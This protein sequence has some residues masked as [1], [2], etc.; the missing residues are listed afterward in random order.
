M[1]VNLTSDGS[2]TSGLG[3][4]GL[5]GQTVTISGK[6]YRLAAANSISTPISLG[7]IHVGS[8]FGTSA[9]SIQNTAT[10]DGYSEGLDAGFGS[11]TGAASD[12]SGTISTLAAGGAN[13][14]SMTVGLGSGSQGT[15]G[16]ISGTVLVNLTSDG[17]GTSGLGTSGLSGQTVTISGK[18]YRLAAANSIS[19]PI[20]LGNIHVGSA[21]GTSALSIQNTAT[22]DGYS[23]GLDAGF[24]SVTGSASDNSGT[25]SVLAAGGANGTSMTVGLGSGTQGTAG[26]ISG[27]VLVNL[28]SD[29]SGTSG[30]G[31]SGLGGQTVTISG[32]VYRL[33]AANT[34]TTPISLGNVHVG[35]AFGTSALS[36]SNTATNDGYSEGLDAGFGSVTGA[37]SDNSGTISTLAAG[38]ANSTSMT[39]GLGSGSQGTAG[40]ISGTVL[41]NLTSDGSGTSGLGTSG[42]SGQTVTIS[43]KVYRLAAA[44]SISTPISLGNIHVGSASGLRP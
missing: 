7:N 18:V 37:A 11:V 19:T 40:S 10:N 34:I 28:T 32:K 15:A 20:S 27:T 2:G 16:S 24:G 9:L 38:G 30:L 8:A 35:S 21:F 41:V 26:S 13:S 36:I 33:A 17:S 6:V 14:T 31:T 5:S 25:I 4:S 39:V 23:E 43:G 22:N 44:N 12:N 3:T 29:G 1:L 42:L